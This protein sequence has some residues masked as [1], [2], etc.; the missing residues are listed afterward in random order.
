M[1]ILE[2]EQLVLQGVVSLLESLTLRREFH[3]NCRLLTE[4]RHQITKDVHKQ[5]RRQTKEVNYENL[6]K[7][8]Y[9]EGKSLADLLK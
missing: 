2:I 3:Q 7:L 1:A 9:T 6:Q 8:S 4:Q 5:S